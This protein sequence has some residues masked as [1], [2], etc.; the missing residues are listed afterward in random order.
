MIFDSSNFMNTD[1]DAI[2]R[3]LL[4]MQFFT[5][6]LKVLSVEMINGIVNTVY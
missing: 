6:I 5:L 1:C 3:Y 2:K 4:T